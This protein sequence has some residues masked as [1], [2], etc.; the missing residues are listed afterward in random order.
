MF[1]IFDFFI[2]MS[3][4]SF[5]DLVIMCIFEIVGEMR[6]RRVIFGYILVTVFRKR[7]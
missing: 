3:G 6:E 1:L 2:F 7:V 5:S 4:F